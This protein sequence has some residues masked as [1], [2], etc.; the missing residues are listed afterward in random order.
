M[1]AQSFRLDWAAMT[2]RG[3]VREQN[4][5]AFVA[6]PEVGVWIVA[7]GMGGFKRGEWA[8]ELITG[9]FDG[10]EPQT[11]LA[12]LLNASTQAVH[13]ANQTIFAKSQELGAQIGSTVV[14]L[15]IVGDEFGVFWAGDSRAYLLRGGVF[16]QVTRDHTQVQ[17]LVERGRIGADEAATHPMSHVL[18]KAVGV[19]PDLELEGVTETV[20]S[21]DL[22]LLCSDGLHG[23][24][25]NDEICELI[26][27]G[28]IEQSPDRLIRRCLERGA[29]DNVTAIVV[30]AMPPTIL[31]FGSTAKHPSGD[32]HP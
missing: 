29:K 22:F 24:L 16:Y 6:L 17:E 8:S 7:D 23:V 4:E 11:D 9:M 5:D 21:G 12:H 26:T 30:Q 18:S 19:Q 15:A 1:N 10:L 3:S 31:V 14:G 2:D 27:A 20:A 28:S 25:G 13:F 32:M